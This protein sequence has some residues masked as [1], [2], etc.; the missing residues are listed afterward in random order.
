MSG[1]LRQ[2]WKGLPAPVRRTANQAVQA[3]GAAALPLTVMRQWRPGAA[4]GEPV[5]VAGLHGAAVGL[6][7]GAR[8]F[9]RAL[10]DD[11][12]DVRTLDVAQV[13]RA[14]VEL[15]RWAPVPE[16][17][18]AGGVLVSHLN[19]P[20]LALYLQKTGARLLQGRRHIGYWAWE[21]PTAP[22]EWRRAFGYVDEVW[23]PS[24]FTA[25]A[26]RAMAPR[27]VP[28]RIVPH[29]MFVMPSAAPDRARFGLPQDACVV[30]QAFDLRSTVA[31]KNPFGGLEAYL[32][33]VP[34]EGGPA[35]L[36]CKVVGIEAFPSL[37]A[38]LKARVA[39]RSDLILIAETLSSQDMLNLTASADIVLSLH[40][41]EG[42]G[43]LLA[44][45]MC[46]GKATVATAFS[47]AL[48]FM[49]RQSSVL[50]DWKPV[51]ARDPQGMYRGALWAEP[52]LAE[53]AAELARLIGDPG[54]RRSLGQRAQARAYSYFD[55][56]AWLR[57]VGSGLSRP[58][59]G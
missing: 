5:I 42:F 58:P 10:A 12:V 9:A 52:D 37:F 33:A 11:G 46:F 32:R 18:P 51:A 36:V 23:C 34:E 22:P 4:G 2:A 57:A 15:G 45:A 28:V 41:A 19:P 55:R 53:A 31:R 21:L 20:E 39:V 30:L 7:Q 50:I 13:L 44:E 29:P 1:G 25:S 56:D 26:L 16:D 59:P 40:R 38:E 6:G 48:D 54:A 35:R 24:S 14:P 43:L 3:F 27:R 49:D 17:L 8:L 47:G